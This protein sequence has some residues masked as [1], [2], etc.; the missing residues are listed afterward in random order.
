MPPGPARVNKQRRGAV[1]NLPVAKLHKGARG[2]PQLGQAAQHP[3]NR[4]GRK[5]QKKKKKKK[6]KK[7]V[8][9]FDFDFF[10]GTYSFPTVCM[11][12]NGS[13]MLARLVFNF[14]PSPPCRSIPN[15]VKKLCS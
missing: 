8:I 5:K 13:W 10:F 2:D 12:K 15:R 3:E 1:Q 11:G 7:R 6:K 14:F 9:F 4:V